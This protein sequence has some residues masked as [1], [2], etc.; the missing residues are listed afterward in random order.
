[1]QHR[2]PKFIVSVGVLLSLWGCGNDYNVGQMEKESQAGD[3]TAAEADGVADVEEEEEEDGTDSPW[4]EG[5][6][7]SDDSDDPEEEE[8][9]EEEEYVPPPED[10]CTDTSDLIYVIDRDQ[11]ELY[12]FDPETLALE[13]LGVLDCDMWVSPASM[14][15]AR[16]GYAYVR[17]SDQ[18]LYKVNLEDFTCSLTSY[19]DSQGFG[20][21]GMGY[22]TNSASTWQ[23]QLY[24]ANSESIAKLSTTDWSLTELGNIPSQAELTGNA[25]GELWGFLPLE[26]PAE[27]VQLDKNSAAILETVQL[28]GFPEPSTIDTFAFATW[29][30]DYFLFVRTYGLGRSTD[31]YHVTESGEMSMVVEGLGINVVG[32]GVSTCAP[33]E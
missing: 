14:G 25:A 11:E 22:A 10:D 21:F 8:E 28:S 32:A 13:S 15:V 17:Y 16:D 6:N 31:V 9:E 19:E 29:G 23:D 33:T 2:F 4:E 18:S 24:V 20:S 5:N 27:L 1:M 12:L 30:G 26:S 7:E 3:D